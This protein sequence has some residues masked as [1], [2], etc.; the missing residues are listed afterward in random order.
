V[1]ERER[2]IGSYYTG[3]FRGKK[4][5]YT[6]QSIIRFVYQTVTVPVVAGSRRRWE[7]S[8]PTWWSHWATMTWRWSLMSPT[9]CQGNF[10]CSWDVFKQALICNFTCNTTMYFAV[11]RSSLCVLVSHSSIEYAVHSLVLQNT[12]SGKLFD[13]GL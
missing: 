7:K 5:C 13:Q 8:V 10:C 9:D 3:W 2:E 11:T 12:D 1:R 6:T 4:L